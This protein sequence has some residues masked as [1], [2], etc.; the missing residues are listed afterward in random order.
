MGLRITTDIHGFERI[1]V[2]GTIVRAFPAADWPNRPKRL[3]RLLMAAVSS[4]HL[5]VHFA[6]ADVM[7]LVTMLAV[8]PFHRCRLTTLDFF[9]GSPPV[10]RRPMIR[11]CL[12]RVD[13]ML[14]YFRDAGVFEREYGISPERFHYIP[15]KVNGVELIRQTPASDGGYIFTGGRSRRDFATLFAAIAPLGYPVKI[16]TSSEADMRP[17]GSSLEGLTIPPNVEISTNDREQDF[18]IRTMAGARM[19]VLPIVRD[20]TTQAGIGV[21]LQAMALRKCVII[22][23]GMGV[24]DVLTDS[25]ALIVP[26]G[27]P[28]ALRQVIERAWNDE[29][30][31]ERYAAAGYAYAGRL[32]G[33]DDLRRNVL[34][35]LP[36][37]SA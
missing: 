29:D 10:S 17:H 35:A 21:Y 22:S 20:T 23:S 31:R 12:N 18:F 19:V 27:D 7:F 2:P 8:I 36:G 30:L 34:N 6:L 1:T 25:Q 11:W 5:V 33:E 26:A 32:G 24:S 28:E 15:F 16:V 37:A 13:R 9:I 4:D 3:F 14:V